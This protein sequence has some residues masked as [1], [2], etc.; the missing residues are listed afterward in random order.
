MTY[1]VLTASS[2]SAT[3]THVTRLEATSEVAAYRA[4]RECL[5]DGA[6]IRSIVAI[7]R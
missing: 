6:V 4:V 7:Q 1:E 2:P 5:P 3:D